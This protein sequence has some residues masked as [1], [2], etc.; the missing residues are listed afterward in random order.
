MFCDCRIGL[1]RYGTRRVGLDEDDVRYIRLVEEA[2]GGNTHVAFIG[3]TSQ[4]R[5]RRSAAPSPSPSAAPGS[6]E[7]DLGRNLGGA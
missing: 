7:D 5:F 2:R 3:K 6:E 4:S 1:G